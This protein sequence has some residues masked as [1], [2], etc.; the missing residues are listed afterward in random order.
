MADI[1]NYELLTDDE[2]ADVVE[3]LANG[4]ENPTRGIVLLEAA[5]RLRDRGDSDG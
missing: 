4:Q 3:T 5:R 1:S 2:L